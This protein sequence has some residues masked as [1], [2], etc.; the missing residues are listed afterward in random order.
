M[1]VDPLIVT[2]PSPCITI[3]RASGLF[4]CDT[5]AGAQPGE[6][7]LLNARDRAPVRMLCLEAKVIENVGRFLLASAKS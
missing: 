2:G 3:D 4:V 5:I 1:T 7:L 6:A